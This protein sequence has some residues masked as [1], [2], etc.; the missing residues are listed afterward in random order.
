MDLDKIFR[1]AENWAQ[2]K[3]QTL[4]KKIDK[5]ISEKTQ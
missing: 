1:R 3:R 5:E 4:D 2:L